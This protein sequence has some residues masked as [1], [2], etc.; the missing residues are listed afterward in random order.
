MRDEIDVHTHTLASGHAYNTIGEMAASGEGEGAEAFGHHRAR[1][2]DG[3]R[4]YENLLPK[5]KGGRSR[6]V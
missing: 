2:G 3:R 6:G 4:A 1:P 5:L